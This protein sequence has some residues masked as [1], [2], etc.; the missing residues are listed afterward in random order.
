MYEMEEIKVPKKQ[1]IFAYILLFLVI[2]TFSTIRSQKLKKDVQNNYAYTKS[3][4]TS[5]EKSLYYL[6][7]NDIENTD[8]EYIEKN[9]KEKIIDKFKDTNSLMSK[10]SLQLSYV[11]LKN[12][13]IYKTTIKDEPFTIYNGLVELKW[14]YTNKDLSTDITT[15]E[16][17][18]Y[19]KD[20]N[21]TPY[22]ADIQ[23]KDKE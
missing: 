3:I 2:V 9:Y 10:E 6:Y 11:Q 13:K 8:C 21:D 7:N 14:S 19:L 23:I 4:Q 12:K 5:I 15:K 17:I 20:V 18:V 16:I 1:K 22:I